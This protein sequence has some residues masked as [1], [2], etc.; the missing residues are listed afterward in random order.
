MRAHAVRSTQH[1]HCHR[2]FFSGAQNSK[3]NAFNAHIPKYENRSRDTFVQ[4]HIFDTTTH[5]H[6][7]MQRTIERKRNAQK[8][9]TTIDAVSRM[10]PIW[11]GCEWTVK[12]SSRCSRRVLEMANGLS[13]AHALVCACAQNK[14]KCSNNVV[15]DDRAWALSPE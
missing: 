10:V 3:Q 9:I 5:S 1:A 13:H 12:N 2:H 15:I 7:F 11:K 14:E 4:R 8:Y 6:T